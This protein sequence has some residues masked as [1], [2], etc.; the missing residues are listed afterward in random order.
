MRLLLLLLSM[1]L[2][3]SAAVSPRDGWTQVTDLIKSDWGCASSARVSADGSTITH[4]SGASYQ[5]F[6]LTGSRLEVAGDFSIVAELESSVTAN[7]VGISLTGQPSTGGQFW[8]GLKRIDATVVGNTVSTFYWTGASATNVSRSFPIP[9]N[10]QPGPV[11]LEVARIGGDLVFFVN[12]R[13]AGRYADPGLFSNGFVYWGLSAAA[14]TTVTLR[15]MIATAPAASTS[16]TLFDPYARKAARTETAL[17]NVA[18]AR[19]FYFGSETAPADL[20]QDT[21]VQTIGREFNQI[22]AG[23]A[24]KFDTTHPA[25]GRYNFCPGDQVVRFAEANHMRVRGHVLLWHNQLPAWVTNGTFTPAQAAA[26]MKEHIETEVTHF[27]GR[28]TWW[29]VVNE[30]ILDAAPNG[31]RPTFWS[32]N[33][34]PNYIDEAFRLAHAA[35]PEAKLFYNDYNVEGLN[36]KSNAM[37]TMVRG[38]L[39]RGVPIHGVG[40]QAHFV[41]NAAPSLQSLTENIKRFGDLGLEVHITE[42]D[43]RIQSPTT[44]QK[45]Q[46][47]ATEYRNMVAAC[48][49]HPKCTMITVWGVTDAISW[50]DKFFPGYSDALLFDRQYQ[51]KG[52]YTST[53]QEVTQF[54]LKPQIYDGG[55]IIHAGLTNDVSP[56]SLVDLYGE[57]MA[58]RTETASGATLPT[59]LGGVRVLVNGVAVP[60]Y[61]VSPGLTILQLPYETRLGIAH[62]KVVNAGVESLPVPLKVKAAAPFILT[63]GANRAIVQNSDYSLNSDSN[64]AKAGSFIT[65][66]MMGSG[67]L[68]GAVT[69]GVP[70]P[71]DRPYAQTLPTSATLGS[72]NAPVLFAGMTGGLY[73]LMQVNLT[74]PS[75]VSGNVELRVNVG[76]EQSNRPL[77]C[78]EP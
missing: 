32:N 58:S 23:N 65:V 53:L 63:Y 51:P 69:T 13:E 72:A 18:S 73:G 28:I 56:G 49:A 24:L 34:G 78:V 40:L 54:V 30:A 16:V 75:G 60:L 6:M 19:G 11:S 9:G 66:Y 67:P 43:V 20:L 52:A 59:T 76:V 37:F 25:A 41:N 50:V 2:A 57:R 35:D 77:V 39:N 44:P 15:S 64:C 48:R 3:S 8:E 55:A 12:G 71:L 1:A 4:T 33:V 10:R 38:M 68:D 21:Y 27:K 26:L 14:N 62:V 47:Q 70:V 74:I 36:A 17:R 61:Y 46:Q 7:S 45:L 5:T 31:L 29:D 22:V 42:L